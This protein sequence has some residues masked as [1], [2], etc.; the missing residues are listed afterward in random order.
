MVVVLRV[1]GYGDVCVGVVGEC[2]F[3]VCLC[4]CEVLVVFV[5]G[6]GGW[7]GC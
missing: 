5:S 6:G 4:W 3:V 2:V 1:A 7:C